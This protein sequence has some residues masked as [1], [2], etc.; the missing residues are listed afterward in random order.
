[1]YITNFEPDIDEKILERGKKY[2]ANGFVVDIWST[3]PNCYRAVV[4]GRIPYDVEIHI[5][6][7]GAVLH[8]HCD[9]PYNLGEYCK[10]EVAVLFAIRRH[11]EQGTTLKRKGKKRGFR[12]MLLSKS[13]NELANLLC[14]LAAKYDM[15]EEIVYH[16]EDIY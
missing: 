15:R 2:F 6:A 4:E 7:N 13:K 14:V 3:E 16:F 12:T 10:H 1:M 11:M 8:H 5:D 9:C